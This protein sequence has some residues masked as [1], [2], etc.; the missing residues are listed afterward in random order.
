[1]LTLYVKKM[2][3]DKNICTYILHVCMYKHRCADLCSAL[4]KMLE[5]DEVLSVVEF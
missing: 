5:G 3:A 1:M 4:R 2:F